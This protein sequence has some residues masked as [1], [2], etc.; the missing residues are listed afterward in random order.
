MR[1]YVALNFCRI[2]YNHSAPTDPADASVWITGTSVED[3]ANQIAFT[4]G[5]MSIVLVDVED[6][7][8][9]YFPLDKTNI[10]RMWN[11][12]VM[13]FAL[14]GPIFQSDPVKE[15]AKSFQPVENTP[16]KGWTDVDGT[17]REPPP[18]DGKPKKPPTGPPGPP[19]TLLQA[20]QATVGVLNGELTTAAGQLRV[21]L[22]AC[23]GCINGVI[24]RYVPGDNDALT[25]R[26]YNDCLAI[27]SR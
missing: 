5:Q 26:E 17:K 25:N 22:Q 20:M 14:N 16:R 11:F 23:V 6:L 19:L 1:N 15:D 4:V 10:S 12:A 13:G 9:W 8:I 27:L 2:N 7:G 3:L 18:S 21:K 24:S